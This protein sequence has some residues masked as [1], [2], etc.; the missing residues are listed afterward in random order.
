MVTGKSEL[1]EVVLMTLFLQILS[2]HIFLCSPTRYVQKDAGRTGLFSVMNGHTGTYCVC[3]RFLS[4][5][6]QRCIRMWKRKKLLLVFNAIN[7]LSWYSASP[8]SVNV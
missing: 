1:L 8:L 3:Y 4:R 6:I 7:S 2:H 5:I